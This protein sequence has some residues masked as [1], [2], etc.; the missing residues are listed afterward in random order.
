MCRRLYHNITSKYQHYW[1]GHWGTNVQ[2]KDTELH[3]S[4]NSSDLFSDPWDECESHLCSERSTCLGVQRVSWLSLTVCNQVRN[5]LRQAIKVQTS[6]D[7]SLHNQ[8]S[9]KQSYLRWQTRDAVLMREGSISL[10]TISSEVLSFLCLSVSSF[11]QAC[12]YPHYCSGSNDILCFTGTK[13]HEKANEA[14]LLYVVMAT[15]KEM[16]KERKGFCS[17]S[18]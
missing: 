8:D 9:Q 15:V 4:L 10:W 12:T 7:Q 16:C 11:T 1:M 14:M 18:D 6:V 3:I 2:I 5:R 17:S 13:G